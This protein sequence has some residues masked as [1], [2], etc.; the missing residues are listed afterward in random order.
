MGCRE[1][2]FV[3]KSTFDFP[4]FLLFFNAK[5]PI[6]PIFSIPS[7]LFSYFLSNHAAGHP[8]IGFYEG[9]MRTSLDTQF[10][11]LTEQGYRT[12]ELNY[13][14]ARIIKRNALSRAFLYNNGVYY[15][16]FQ[17]VEQLQNEIDTLSR[18]RHPRIVRFHGSEQKGDVIY[19]FLDFMAGVRVF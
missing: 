18:L 6:F 7:F 12:V 15:Y 16:F 10:L 14:T 13:S 17:E 4:I 3:D 8:G 2:I 19:L 9:R 1:A 11:G 5:F